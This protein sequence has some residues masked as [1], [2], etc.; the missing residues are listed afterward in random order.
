MTDFRSLCAELLKGLDENKHEEVNYPGHLR[1]VMAKARAALA[2]PQS[3]ADG[4]VGEIQ[5]ALRGHCQYLK[6]WGCDTCSIDIIPAL[7]CAAKLLERL[8]DGPAVQNRE[9]A[10]VVEQP[11]DE[12]LSRLWSVAPYIFEEHGGVAFARAVL[13]R[14]GTSNLAETRSSLGD[15]SVVKRLVTDELV[16][17]LRTK[18]ATEKANRCHYSAKLLTR[19]ADL[20]EQLADKPAVQ[21]REPASVITEPSN[22]DLD[23]LADEILDGDRASRRDFARAVLAR[24]GNPAPQPIPVSERLPGDQ[25]CWWYEPDEDCGY[26]G[27]WTL[28]RIRNS[29]SCYTHWLPAHALPLPTTTEDTNDN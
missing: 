7:T 25:L 20:L 1:V 9:P 11:S 19:A 27:M 13:A 21:S 6:R 3:S 29:T 12:E 5:A 17:Q 23:N 10:S 22:H 15:P 14:W 26:G 2:E 16:W 24:W 18:S 28:L 4:E 8:S